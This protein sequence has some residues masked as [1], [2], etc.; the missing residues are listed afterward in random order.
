MDG[1]AGSLIRWDL[2][3]AFGTVIKNYKQSSAPAFLAP[4]DSLQR[5]QTITSDAGKKK[6]RLQTCLA[7]LSL[8][9]KNVS[10]IRNRIKQTGSDRPT[11]EPTEG[12]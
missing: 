8:A 7:Q 6:K 11:S 4:P 10:D 3:R 12:A 2:S 9:G 1:K 5:L